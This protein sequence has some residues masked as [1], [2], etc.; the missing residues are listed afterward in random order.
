MHNQL[1]AQII[2][3]AETSHKCFVI[4]ITSI[5]KVYCHSVHMLSVRSCEVRRGISTYQIMCRL[6]RWPDSILRNSKQVCHRQINEFHSNLIANMHCQAGASI[7][8]PVGAGIANGKT[9]GGDNWKFEMR[10]MFKLL[11]IKN[12]KPPNFNSKITIIPPGF[13]VGIH[14]ICILAKVSDSFKLQLD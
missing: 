12:Y 9:G 3:Y 10:G 14:C 13:A 2:K 7:P 6:L 11:K 1:N 4:C 5:I 8:I